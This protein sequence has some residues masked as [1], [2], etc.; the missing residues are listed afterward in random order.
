[1]IAI[2]LLLTVAGSLMSVL[3]KLLERV[4]EYRR[5][6]VTRTKTDV[7]QRELERALAEIAPA[8]GETA[9]AAER[10]L[11][12]AFAHETDIRLAADLRPAAALLPLQPSSL[13]RQST[14]IKVLTG[15]AM[16]VLVFAVVAIW[17]Y[18]PQVKALG[19]TVFLAF[20]L[21]L[22]MAAGM[23]VQGLTSNYNENRP[24][25]DVSAS[26][27]LFPLL[28]SPIV[29]YPIWLVGNKQGAG[30]FPFYAAFLNGYFWQS[31]V[32]AV[33]PV[34]PPPVANLRPHEGVHPAAQKPSGG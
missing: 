25:L 15:F 30:L 33:R 9:D 6:R 21:L 31:V 20:G 4:G 16:V 5:Q 13:R 34:E 29:F 32:S 2:S 18:W 10:E 27:L 8:A 11:G 12:R 28:F 23:F 1:M 22:T 17:R 19:D 14:S 7:D 3:P 26:R 24:L